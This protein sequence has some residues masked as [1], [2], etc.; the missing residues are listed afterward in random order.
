MVKDT[1]EACHYLLKDKQM[2]KVSGAAACCS[3][4]AG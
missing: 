1:V 2:T 3:V 4:A